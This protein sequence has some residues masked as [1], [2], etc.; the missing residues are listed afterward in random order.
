MLEAAPEDL[1]IAGGFVHVVGTPSRGIPV[2]DV[3]K[4]SYFEPAALPPG[5]PLGLEG[6]ARFTPGSFVTWSNA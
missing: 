1:D 4:K 2:A 3:A 6:H 5:Q